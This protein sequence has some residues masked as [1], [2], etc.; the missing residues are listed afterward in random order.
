MPLHL[1]V[2]L[3]A[4]LFVYYDTGKR[5]YGSNK[6]LLW[7]LGAAI[8]PY[9]VVVLYLLIGRRMPRGRVPKTVQS[10]DN[11][12]WQSGEPVNVSET[13]GCP[14]CAS[15]VPASFQQCPKCGYT[16]KLLCLECGRALERD[17]RTCPY[18]GA[19]APKK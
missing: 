12:S 11:A 5:G 2:C 8:L 19:D 13:V 16:L 9:V 14:M 3:A 18:C 1:L 7:T 15:Q 4:A 6:R 10:G 17:W